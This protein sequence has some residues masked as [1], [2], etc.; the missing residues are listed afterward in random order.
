ML[1]WSVRVKV[2][3]SPS[4]LWLY[5]SFVA[6]AAGGAVRL[7]SSPPCFFSY[8]TRLSPIL[9]SFVL[10]PPSLTS[11]RQCW[12]TAAS[13]TSPWAS[14]LWWGEGG[15]TST[16]NKLHQRRGKGIWKQ[17]TGN[18]KKRLLFHIHRAH[19]LNDPIE[20]LGLWGW[21]QC[22]DV[23]MQNK[24]ACFR[25]VFFFSKKRLVQWHDAC[26]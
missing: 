18:K 15:G 4:L 5:C 6:P 26:H 3:L 11:I 13:S 9:S 14:L 17:T 24:N 1:Q 21:N 16:L 19:H 8:I 12:A 2:I 22:S 20:K 25:S 10:S 7:E 23:D